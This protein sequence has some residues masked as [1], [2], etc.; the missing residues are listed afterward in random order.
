MLR[1]I[2][3]RKLIDAGDRVL[4]G[5]SGGADS[6]CLLHLLALLQE[7][8]DFSLYAVHVHHHLRADSADM[9]AALVEE[10]CRKLVWWSII[11]SMPWVSL[12]WME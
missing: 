8:L 1:T 11:L 4:V 9:D 6:M 2:E 5:C 10:T 7:P 3:E 12:G